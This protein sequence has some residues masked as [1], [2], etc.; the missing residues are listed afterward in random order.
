MKNSDRPHRKVIA[1]AAP[2]QHGAGGAAVRYG[3]PLEED[4]VQPPQSGS[5]GTVLSFLPRD[6][7]DR[8]VVHVAAQH[9]DRVGLRVGKNGPELVPPG[10]VP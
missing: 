8:H 5:R 4:V 2:I 6:L 10:R 9:H 1:G 7:A 3:Q